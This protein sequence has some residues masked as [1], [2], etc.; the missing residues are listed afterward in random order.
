MFHGAMVAIV[1]PFK[2]GKI[3]F[4]GL[5]NLIEFQIA[6]GTTGIVSCG[7]TGEPSTLS[8]DE[9]QRVTEI[10]V[11]QVAGRVPVIAGT[12]SNSTEEAIRL[13]WHAKKIGANAVL[14]INPYYNKP[15]QE[16]I[17]QHFKAT[18]K[19]VDIPI[20]IYNIPSRTGSNIEPSTVKRL[21]E[22]GS[23]VG[24]KEASGSIK[25]IM[26]I[27]SQA[28]PAMFAVFSGDDDLIYPVMAMGGS[29]VISVAS[30]IIPAKIAELCDSLQKVSIG[31]KTYYGEAIETRL[32]FF[33][34]RPLFAALFLET[35]PAP[36]KAAMK[37]MGLIGSDEVRLPLVQM[38]DL[39][40]AHLGKVLENYGLAKK[41][42]K[43]K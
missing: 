40:K 42:P 5:R 13:T 12:G 15:T 31:G 20:I 32:S 9:H 27:L 30:N 38:S 7:T 41:T 26:D 19:A 23:I 2:N 25:Q 11:E 8:W 16:G 10:T 18:A 35:N 1:T 37:M 22:I 14:M 39:N 33:A 29:G 17:Y 36:I 3:D 24:I 21:S 4:P 28:N 6:N 43:I 34:L